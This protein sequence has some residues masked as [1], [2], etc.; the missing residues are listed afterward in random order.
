LATVKVKA[1]QGTPGNDTLVGYAGADTLDGGAGNDTLDGGNGSDTYKFGKASGNDTISESYDSSVNTDRVLLDAGIAPADVTVRRDG[2]GSDLLLTIAGASN[3]LRIASYFYQDGVSPYALEQIAFADGTVWNLATVK[4]KALQGTP[5]NDTLVGYAG[6]DTL[7]GG[8]GADR[9]IGGLGNDTYVVDNTGDV[10]AENLNEGMDTIQSSISIAALAANVE[11]LT[12]TGAAALNSIG[13]SLNNVITGNAAANT[14]EGGLGSDTLSGGAGADRFVFN[15]ALGNTNLD[16]VLD[17]SKV[18]GD[19]I[20]LGRTAF[21]KLTG[22]SNLSGNFRLSTQAAVGND[23]YLV[24]NTG[25]GQLFYDASGNGTGTMQL[26]ATLANKP[27]DLTGA[28][29][30]VI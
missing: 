30:V 1:L 17:F 25:N 15:S 28:Q 26:F 21:S 3:Q 13:N 12:L 4:A 5:G 9:L 22:L 16:T 19:S 7:D 27:L 18:Q 20:A 6:A 14:L 24:Y 10:V 29:F 8:A 11:N 23:D 2:T